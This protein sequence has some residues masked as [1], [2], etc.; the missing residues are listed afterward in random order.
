[1]SLVSSRGRTVPVKCK[2]TVST[3]NSILDPRCFSSFEFR[4]SSIEFR[5]SSIE[6]RVS[7]HS[8]NFSRISNSDFEK[9]IRQDN[10]NKQ[11]LHV[12]N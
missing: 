10:S 12:V 9:T 7:S 2:L 6:F 3:R 1:M 4:V 5:V 11:T 8:K